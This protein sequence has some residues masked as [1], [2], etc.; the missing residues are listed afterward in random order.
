MLW[1]LRF[2]LIGALILHVHAA[3]SLTVL[4]RRACPVKYQ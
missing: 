3:Y 2:V 4:N 1:L